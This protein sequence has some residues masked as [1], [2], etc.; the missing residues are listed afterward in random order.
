V[1]SERSRGGRSRRGPGGYTGRANA[2]QGIDYPAVHPT[3]TNAKSSRW[4]KPGRGS[5][6]A[7]AR[8]MTLEQRQN[9]PPEGQNQMKQN[10]K[11]S[12]CGR[13]VERTPPIVAQPTAFARE[14]RTSL[15]AFVLVF[16]IG[17]KAAGPGVGPAGLDTGSPY[18]VFH[19]GC[20]AWR[21]NEIATASILLATVSNANE[22]SIACRLI[23]TC[24]LHRCGDEGHPRAL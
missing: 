16:C 24:S 8:E 3:R 5:E 19:G 12:W 15:S 20:M 2:F 23:A 1:T 18:A 13:A 11:V 10:Q 9:H 21:S 22:R 14:I 6:R 17:V 7:K 4:P